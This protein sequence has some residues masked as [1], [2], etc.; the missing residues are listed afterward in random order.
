[1]KT[2]Y[3][4][5][6]IGIPIAF[7]LFSTS[8]SFAQ[9]NLSGSWEF[10]KARSSPEADFSKYE[11]KVVRTITQT[12]STITYKDTYIHAGSPDWNTADEQFAL[13]KEKIEKHGKDE[14]KKFTRW[15]ADKKSLTLTYQNKYYQEGVAK[16]MV[17]AETYTLSDN[18]K[19]LVINRSFKNPVTGELK[20]V[21]TF[22]KRA[23]S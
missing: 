1:M 19:T 9:L 5:K 16:E 10:D 14:V 18:G 2:H 21:S 22:K 20:T 11:G 17:I 4:F 3:C 13:D 8:L 23:G 15:S 12:A 6:R 7:M